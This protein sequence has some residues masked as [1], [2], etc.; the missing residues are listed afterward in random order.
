LISSSVKANV[1]FRDEGQHHG[2]AFSWG[3]LMKLFSLTG[4][5]FA[6]D[7]RCS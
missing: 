7:E 3:S 6:L 5:L 4:K 2:K 1:L